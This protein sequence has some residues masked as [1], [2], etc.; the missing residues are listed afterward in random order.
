MLDGHLY[1]VNV[2]H[3]IS[4]Y[5]VELI[6]NQLVSE[7]SRKKSIET[8]CDINNI[9]LHMLCYDPWDSNFRF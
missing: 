8:N 3:R 1:S 7:A 4:I 2:L 6:L 9:A 5:E